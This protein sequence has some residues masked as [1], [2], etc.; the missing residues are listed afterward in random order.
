MNL[1]AVWHDLIQ[2]NF[3]QIWYGI[4]HAHWS[5]VWA[6]TSM[7]ATSAAVV[8]ALFAMNSWHR[9]ESFKAKILFKKAV[10]Q[11]VYCLIKLPR[12]LD[13]PEIIRMY[14]K[15]TDE[16]TDRLAEACYAW[17]S[18][19]GSLEKDKVV[20]DSWKFINDNH[21]KYT[22]GEV[23]Y[24]D[25]HEHCAVIVNRPITKKRLAWLPRL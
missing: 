2:G 7:I 5:N 9:Q 24:H 3:S 23:T 21:S 19:D 16:L 18:L 6:C 4:T 8:I 14:D 17:F 22:K 1:A 20:F 12:H 10:L 15:E 11:Y 13:T 25:I